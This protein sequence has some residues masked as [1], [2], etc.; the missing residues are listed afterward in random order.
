MDTTDPDIRF[1]EWGICHYC[2]R[3]EKY[4]SE[5]AYNSEAQQ[6]R[7]NQFIS[8][9][10]KRGRN[11]KYDCV[12]GLSGGV[13][14]SYVACKV[15]E[16]GLRPLAIHFDSGWNSEIAV[17]NIENIVKKLNLQLLTYVCD[18]EVMRDLQVSFLKASVANCDVPQDHSFYAMLWRTAKKMG[19]KY[20]ISGHNMSTESIL[21][22]AWGYN[23]LD[24]KHLGGIHRKYGKLK[25][26]NY[27]TL[28]LFDLYFY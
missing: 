26:K 28:N 13:D 27:P 11:K 2:R 3:Y 15:V 16:L 24:P 25:L 23:C 18:W 12:I 21:P 1:D 9:I 10:K 17:R 5:H 6:N 19:A 7:F 14:S 22:T 20:I 4:I 8:E